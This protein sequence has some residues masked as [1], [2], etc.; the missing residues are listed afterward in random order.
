MIGCFVAL[1]IL[2]LLALAVVLIPVG[3]ALSLGQAAMV[4]GLCVVAAQIAWAAWRHGGA[5]ALVLEIDGVRHCFPA[6][7]EDDAGRVRLYLD[8]AVPALTVAPPERGEPPLLT[9][10]ALQGGAFARA[11]QRL[12][13]SDDG[14]GGDP[15]LPRLDF[16]RSTPFARSGHLELSRFGVTLWRLDLKLGQRVSVPPEVAAQLA[17]G[18]LTLALVDR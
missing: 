10:L 14:A 2:C 4:V 6:L 13:P 5:M 12:M 11:A 16:R 3:T 18:A 8:L 15:S 9:A 17:A 7:P 1:V